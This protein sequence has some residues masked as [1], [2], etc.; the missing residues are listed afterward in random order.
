MAATGLLQCL[1]AYA[2]G[3]ICPRSIEDSRPSLSELSNR[4]ARYLMNGMVE[5]M[6]EV[7]D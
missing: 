4:S 5:E 6:A 2:T 3:G 1:D 7:R